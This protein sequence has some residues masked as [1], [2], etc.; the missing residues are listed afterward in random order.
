LYDISFSGSLL[1][2]LADW[3]DL[4]LGTQVPAMARAD[5]KDVVRLLLSIISINRESVPLT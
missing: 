1:I 5:G 3:S 4:K 2:Q